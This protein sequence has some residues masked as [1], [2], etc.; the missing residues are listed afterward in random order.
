MRGWGE[1][2]GGAGRGGLQVLECNVVIAEVE[3]MFMWH[4]V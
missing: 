3:Y 1:G 2:G 4:M